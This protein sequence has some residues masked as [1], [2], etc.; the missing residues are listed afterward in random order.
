MIDKFESEG[1]VAKTKLIPKSKAKNAYDL[2]AEIRDLIL[3]EPRRYNQ[4]RWRMPLRE[5]EATRQP[6]CGTV[7]CVAGWVESLKFKKRSP[8]DGDWGFSDAP[9]F[10]RGVRVLGL[11]EGQGR[12]LFDAHAA[13]DPDRLYQPDSVQTVAHARRGAAHIRRFQKKYAAQLKAKRV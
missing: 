10:R 9:V 8:L 7:C 2:L 5:I 13:D 6:D 11:T 4:R 1:R 3:E 12:E